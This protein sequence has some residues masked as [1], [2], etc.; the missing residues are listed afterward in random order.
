MQLTPHQ[1]QALEQL[2]AFVQ[3][4]SMKAFVLKGYAGT[5]KTTLVGE[6]VKWLKDKT[7][8]DAVL[9]ATT[10]RA[11]KVLQNKTG[12]P[13]STIHSCIYTFRQVDGKAEEEQDPW[14]SDTG[15]LFL[16]FG[17]K[18]DI[19]QHTDKVYVVDEA[20]MISQEIAKGI[21]TAKF[22][23]GSLLDDFM[24]FSEDRKIVFV[25]DPCQLPPV[26]DN[27]FSAALSASFLQRTYQ[28]EVA[29]FELQE[30]LRQGAG[31][32]ILKIAGRFRESIVLERYEKY[33]KILLPK[34]NHAHLHRDH[35]VLLNKYY[36][37]INKKGIENSIMIGYSNRQCNALNTEIRKRLYQRPD[38]QVGDLLMVVQNSYTVDLVNGDQVKVLKVQK[39]K[40]Q[41]GFTFLKV[42]VQGLHNQQVYDTLLIQDL[43]F[44]KN[45]GLL[46]DE[47]KRLLIDFDIR[48][49]N[50]EISRNSKMYKDNMMS[51]PYLNALRTKFG[52]VVTCHKSQGGEWPHVFLNIYKSL[53]GWKGPQLYRWYYTALTR[54]SEHLHVNDGWWV[55]G[56]DWR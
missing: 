47:A 2:K 13:A 53:Y 5:G 39:H 12:Y 4:D 48:M 24:H 56:Y 17:L 40:V 34:G 41:A 26:A 38:L 54:A 16:N 28:I 42:R 10:G 14:D 22:G 11:A 19:E 7:K 21:H 35:N 31:S 52:Y 15:Q 23:S 44:N 30:V 51:D 20:S 55:E 27:P 6:L 36:D 25:G 37:Q 29:G 33:P 49:R 9:L 46:P 50:R 45:A 18:T 3:D 8:Y 32:E 1:Q 43:L